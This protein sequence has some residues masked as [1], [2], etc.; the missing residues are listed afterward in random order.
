MS[1][2][3]HSK[4]DSPKSPA[5]DP[6]PF[7]RKPLVWIGALLL[8]VLGAA[9]T[10][11]I[12]PFVIT[13]FE[14]ITE[15]GEPIDIDTEARKMA[16]AV[17]LPPGVQISADDVARLDSLDVQKQAEWLE[18]RGGVAFGEHSLVVTITGN[19]SD[20][21]RVTDVRDVSE[22]TAPKRGTLVNLGA[23]RMYVEPSVRMILN[24]GATDSHAMLWD[25][26][27]STLEPYFP[28]RTITLKKDEQHVL[29]IYLYPPPGQLCRPQL[30]MTVIHRDKEYKQNVVPA[31]QRT[32]VMGEEPAEAEQEYS[33][34]YLGGHICAKYVRATPGAVYE[35]GP[36]G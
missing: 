25:P 21:V 6:T 2:P 24:V 34:V 12:K 33:E 17:T 13:T 22:C 11:F 3:V 7:W 26:Q 35:C 9:L 36:E 27:P 4:D 16:R 15:T 10:D 28:N 5:A 8:T 31:D 14:R 1:S 18:S 20:P 32:E 19:R 23:P 30:E 29:V